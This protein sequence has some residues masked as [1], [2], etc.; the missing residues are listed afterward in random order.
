MKEAGRAGSFGAM[1]YRLAYAVGFHPW[2]DAAA[3]PPFVAKAAQM[4]DREEQ[5][6]ARPYGRALDLGTAASGA[7]SSRSAA[8]R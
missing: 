5:G 2:E 3:D 6:R 7:S 4:F 1:N 8:G